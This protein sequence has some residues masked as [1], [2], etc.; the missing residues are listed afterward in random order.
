MTVVINLGNRAKDSERAILWIR[1]DIEIGRGAEVTCTVRPRETFRPERLAV[2]VACAGAFDLVDFKVTLCS[3]FA[4]GGADRPAAWYA[5]AYE[6][7]PRPVADAWDYGPHRA[8]VSDETRLG[9]SIVSRVCPGW[10]DI[11]IVV[12]HRQDSPPASLEVVVL[13]TVMSE[14]AGSHA[15]YRRYG[16][17]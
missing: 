8:V 5:T 16:M 14:A 15:A 9:L 1:S 4:D 12:R 7:R 11:S 13:G 10:R 2:L 17:I 6:L 3:V